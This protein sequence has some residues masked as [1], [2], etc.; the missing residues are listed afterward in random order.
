[1]VSL[2]QKPLIILLIPIELTAN[3]GRVIQHRFSLQDSLSQ[4]VHDFDLS[5]SKHI[6]Y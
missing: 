2:K 4:I 1:M 5:V 6:K 3:V